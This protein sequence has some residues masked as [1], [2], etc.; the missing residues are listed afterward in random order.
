MEAIQA[1]AEFRRLLARQGIAPTWL[2]PDTGIPAMLE[3]YS[4]VRVAG[5][6][7]ENDED[8]L[9][10]QWGTHD[11]GDGA[12]FE[13]DI[14]RQ[15]VVPADEEDRDIWQLSLSFRLSP[16]PHFSAL[17]SGSRWC[18]EP[19]QLNQFRHFIEASPAFLASLPEQGWRVSLSFGSVE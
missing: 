12:H 11:W 3:F 2:R 1:E 10:F 6:V 17:R 15:L 7:L 14:T 19:N 16:Q 13:I 5:C 8:M 18:H 9:L 4:E